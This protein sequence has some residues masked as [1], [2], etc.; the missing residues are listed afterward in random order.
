[1][2]AGLDLCCGLEKSVATALLIYIDLEDCTL[3]L[4]ILSYNNVGLVAE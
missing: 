4:P 1:M 2:L 3:A